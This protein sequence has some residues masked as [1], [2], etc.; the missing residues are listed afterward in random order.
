MEGDAPNIVDDEKVEKI[1]VWIRFWFWGLF[2]FVSWH[3]LF[4]LGSKCCY[5][6]LPYG[7]LVIVA[8]GTRQSWSLIFTGSYPPDSTFFI[9]KGANKPDMLFLSG[10]WWTP[11]CELLACLQ[12]LFLEFFSQFSPVHKYWVLQQWKHKIAKLCFLWDLF[13]RYLCYNWMDL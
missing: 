4:V 2:C 13:Q 12:C 7:I 11:C 5:L 8:G 3:R 6:V 1:L 10:D 9:N